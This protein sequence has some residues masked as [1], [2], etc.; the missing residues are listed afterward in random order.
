MKF[1]CGCILDKDFFSLPLQE[2]WENI[3][4]GCPTAW[5]MIG[6]GLTKGLF[7]IEKSLGRQWCKKIKPR[8][9]EELADVISLIRP[10]CLNAKFREDVESGKFLSITETYFRTKRGDWSPEYIHPVL[11][12]ILSSTHGVPIYQEQIMEICSRFAGLTLVEADDARKAMGKK[13]KEKMAIVKQKFISGAAERGHNEQLAETIFSWINEFSEYGFNKSHAVGYA[14]VGYQTA[15][16]KMHFGQEFFKSM[17]TFSASKQDEQDEKKELIYEARLFGHKIMPPDARTGN[18]DFEFSKDGEIRFGLSHIKDVGPSAIPTIK[19]L[20]K[21]NDEAGFFRFIFGEKS[22]IKKNVTEA[23]IKSGALDYLCD[24]RRIRMLGRFRM[25]SS[26]TQREVDFIFESPDLLGSFS[27]DWLNRLVEAKIP[28]EARVARIVAA[29]NL[30][31]TELGGNR[32][33]L[34][35]AYEKYHLGMTISGNETELYYNEK[36]DTTCRNFLR[37]R[38]NSNVCMGVIIEDIR[39]IIDKN[40]NDMCFMK[41]SDATYILDT[42]VCFSSAYQKCAWIME[43]GKVVMINGKKQD[44]SLIVNSVEHL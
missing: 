31:K 22:K 36:V 41:V 27:E 26:L 35:L 29:W 28:S 25:L 39:K 8:S 12:E 32:K 24:T 11:E 38:N 40:G 30:I 44:T 9:I 18:T 3:P 14:V 20:K 33:K 21:I 1:E 15:Y 42:V 23:L 7:Q 19:P 17:L 6:E 10:G 4:E 16:A 37:I 13:D 5:D 43:P 2:Q 34:T